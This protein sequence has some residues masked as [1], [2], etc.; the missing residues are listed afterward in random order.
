MLEQINKHIDELKIDLEQT[1]DL[2]QLKQVKAKYLS[3]SDFYNE[4]KSSIRTSENK[5][6]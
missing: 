3:K 6:I 1:T 2:E 4:L 5:L